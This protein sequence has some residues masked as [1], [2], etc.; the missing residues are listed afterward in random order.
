MAIQ[1][2]IRYRLDRMVLD[3]KKIMM[4]MPK[5]GQMLYRTPTI[6]VSSDTKT[7]PQLC[8]VTYVNKERLW[9]E[10]EFTASNGIKYK[11]SYK[12]PFSMN[13]I[14]ESVSGGIFV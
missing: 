6:Y 12:L 1:S 9:Y 3:P 8:R 13:S 2:E 5:V 11:E 10:V 4:H 14:R 7:S